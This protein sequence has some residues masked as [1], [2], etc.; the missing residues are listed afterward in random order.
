M[1]KGYLFLIVLNAQV[2]IIRLLPVQERDDDLNP[3]IG[4]GIILSGILGSVFIV[5][6]VAVCL[7]IA[8]HRLCHVLTG[9]I[10]QP[11]QI[12]EFFGKIQSRKVLEGRVQLVQIAQ[13]LRD[14]VFGLG[15]Y[16][17]DAGIDL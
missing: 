10:C 4:S 5:G 1:A 14:G 2:G 13:K 16:V 8:G 9:L 6:A 15:I 3:L 17:V 7:M 12:I 11:L